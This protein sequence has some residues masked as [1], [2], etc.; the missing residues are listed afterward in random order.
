MLGCGLRWSVV[1]VCVRVLVC[2]VCVVRVYV[3]V[4]VCWCVGLRGEG[5]VAVVCVCEGVGLCFFLGGG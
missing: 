2:W 1:R 4:L 5:C 3:R